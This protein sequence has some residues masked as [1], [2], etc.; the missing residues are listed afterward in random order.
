MYTPSNVRK[1]GRFAATMIF[2]AIFRDS[3]SSEAGQSPPSPTATKNA[4]GSGG[5]ALDV[6]AVDLLYDDRRGAPSAGIC[7]LGGGG[8]GRHGQH[9]Q[10]AGQKQ[11]EGPLHM[12]STPYCLKEILARFTPT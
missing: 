4:A 12:A 10:E 2:A 5:F 1:T 6:L 7:P 8:A 9:D 3:S 11:D